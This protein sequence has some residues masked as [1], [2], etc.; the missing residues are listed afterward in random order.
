MT[1]TS[2]LATNRAV[3]VVA[4]AA[5]LVG[6]LVFGYGLLLVP[7]SILGGAH[8]AAIGLSLFLSG[9]FTTER[10]GRRLGLSMATRRTLSLSFAVLAVALLAAFLALNVT[11]FEA[12]EATGRS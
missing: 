12:G 8:V 3:G 7:I 4:V 1:T 10:L 6:A 2:S 11:T 5:M 9:L